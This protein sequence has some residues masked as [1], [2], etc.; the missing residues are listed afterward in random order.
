MQRSLLTERQMEV[1]RYRKDGKTQQQIADIFHTS[2]ANVCSIEKNA[3]RKIQSAQETLSSHYLLDARLIFTLDAGS[4]LFDSI[5]H[6]IEQAG[7]AGIP[8]PGDPMDLINRIRN[9]KPDRIHGRYIKKAI[10]VY[11]ESNGGLRFG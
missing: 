11:L 6:I 9:E 4:D 10:D 7:Q 1:L 5:P 2:K 8:A 3:R